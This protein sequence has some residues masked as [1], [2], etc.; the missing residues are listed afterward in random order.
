MMYSSHSMHLHTIIPI[1][2]HLE[3]YEETGVPE[4]W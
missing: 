1:G 3:N 2:I 4:G